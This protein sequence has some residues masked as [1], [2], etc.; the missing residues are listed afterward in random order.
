MTI[1]RDISSRSTSGDP[2]GSGRNVIAAIGIDRYQRWP[3]L[4]NAVHD[5]TVM[6]EV[7]RRLG[8]QQV[9]PPLLNE[10]ATG[11]AIQSLVTDD[12]VVLGSDDSLVL[13]YAGHGGTRSHHFGDEIIRTGYLIPADAEASPDKVATWLE[14]DAWLRMVS[15]LPPRHILVVLDACHSGIA[16]S[17]VTRWRNRGVGRAEPLSDLRR[18]RS[19]RIM[20][21][22]LG[23][24]VVLDNGPHHGHSLFTG[25]LLEAL[26]YGT[27]G[28]QDRVITGSELWLH[29]RRRIQEYPNSR[30]IPDFGAFDLDER[31]EMVIPFLGEPSDARPATPVAPSWRPAAAPDLDVL[32]HH[33]RRMPALPFAVPPV[34]VAHDIEPL[35]GRSPDAATPRP[36]GVTT[37][38][39][40]ALIRYPGDDDREAAVPVENPAWLVDLGRDQL[41]VL[42]SPTYVNFGPVVEVVSGAV[43]ARRHLHICAEDDRWYVTAHGCRLTTMNAEPN[44]R[45]ALR[46]GQSFQVGPHRFVFRCVVAS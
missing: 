46:D 44:A 15:L 6:L 11:K 10:A 41:H 30:Q 43:T 5:A 3:L 38:H 35:A 42:T 16:L 33:P 2:A 8:F 25:C 28:G 17:R 24:Q 9:T 22:A 26:T 27:G 45:I 40:V 29:V 23:E 36:A 21:S 34:S 20:T 18:R 37:D 31:G 13:F 39:A 4:A 32:D 1:R 7:F 14:L 19:R 12:L